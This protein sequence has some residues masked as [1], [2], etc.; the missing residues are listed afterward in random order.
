MHARVRCGDRRRR[1]DRDV[2]SAHAPSTA[3]LFLAR[4]AGRCSVDRV[5]GQSSIL[6]TAARV[7]RVMSQRR[8]ED[9]GLVPGHEAA[10][11]DDDQR[12]GKRLTTI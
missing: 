11:G 7:P 1:S 3:E 10:S 9:P 4:F 2:N 12:S 8:F 6:R 5:M